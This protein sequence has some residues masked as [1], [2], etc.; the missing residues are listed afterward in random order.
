M[1]T[2]VRLSDPAVED[3]ARLVRKHPQI[4]RWAL[5][6]MIQLETD[7]EA[8]QPLPG[9]LVGWRKLAVGNRDW[10]IVWRVTH[11]EAGGVIVDVA[12]VWA[13]GGRRQ[14][15]GGRRQA[16]AAARSTPK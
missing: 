4:A 7:P 8:G 11:D 3:L 14:A 12:K 9:E 1:R 10:R 5:K 13:A 16:A 6:K 15:A 2:V